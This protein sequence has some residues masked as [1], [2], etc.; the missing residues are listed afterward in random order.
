[1]QI[2]W[3]VIYLAMTIS[4]TLKYPIASPPTPTTYSL[5]SPRGA[6]LATRLWPAKKKTK[7]L[8]LIVHGGG[9]HS[10]YFE[11]IAK[12]LSGAGIICGAYD[13]V[14]NGYSEQ[15]PGT[16]RPGVTH[17]N[18]FDCFVEDVFEAIEWLKKEAGEKNK[19]LPLFLIGES[20][21]GL[22]VGHAFD[23]SSQSLPY[24]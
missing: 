1:M 12:V 7:A 8:C 4:N 3:S 13:Q 9:W 6:K 20:F 15:E 17:V 2:L 14:C 19:D 11:G 21:G 18:S 5:T 10:G 23:P 16:P 24:Y 22:Q